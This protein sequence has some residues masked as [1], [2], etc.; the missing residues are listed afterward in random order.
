MRF[1]LTGGNMKQILRRMGYILAATMT[2]WSM[3]AAPAV[4]AATSKDAVCEGVGLVSG[5]NGC[6]PAPGDPD[7]EKTVQGVVGQAIDILSI[8]VGII[9]V[10]MIIIGGLKYITSQG[11]STNVN[12]AKNTIL[13][14]VIGLVVV[15]LAQ[16]LVKFV[17]QKIGG[18][19]APTT[20]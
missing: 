8:I 2:S 16:T 11:E 1:K 18:D 15:L 17:I 19:S 5:T 20:P 12:S 13:Y 4:M 6:E 10:V 14:A 7:A 9:S 3:L